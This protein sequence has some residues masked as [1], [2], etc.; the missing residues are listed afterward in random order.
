[1][2][3]FNISLL[4][5]CCLMVLAIFHSC[6]AQNSPQ[7]YLAV[8]NDARAQVGVGP[9]S[10]DAGLASRAQ[11][12][13]NSRTGDCNLIHSGAGENLAK[14]SGDFT[15]RAAVELWVG[16]K[17]NYNY[18]TNQCASGQVCG[19]YTQV[20]WRNSVRLGCGRARCNNG[21]WFISCNYDPVGNYVGQRPY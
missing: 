17:P 16:E 14:G 9:M 21:W 3:L 13:A 20:V 15:G 19:H 18:G 10:W 12:Y 2:G 1:M 8:H 6:D 7:D 5:T 11:N 4:L